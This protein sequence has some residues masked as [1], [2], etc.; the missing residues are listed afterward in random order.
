MDAHQVDWDRT[1]RDLMPRVYNYFR[2]RFQNEHLAQDLNS[3]AW[4]NVWKSRH[5]YDPAKGQPITWIMTIARNIATDHLKRKHR[6][7]P[8]DI[9]ENMPGSFSVEHQYE[10]VAELERLAELLATLDDDKRELI[11]LRYGARMSYKEI[12]AFTGKNENSIGKYLQ[13]AVE[14]LRARWEVTL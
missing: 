7:I 13:R 3:K 14:E 4:V 1:Y 9:I 5:L 6:E 8:L 10:R 12:A 2:Y 11:S